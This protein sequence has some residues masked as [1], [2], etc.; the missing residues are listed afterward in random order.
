MNRKVK[1][2]FA[3]AIALA[4]PRWASAQLITTSP[5]PVTQTAP[6]TVPASGAPK[7]S[8]GAPVISV[9][10]ASQEAPVQVIPAPAAAATAAPPQPKLGG[11]APG[12]DPEETRTPYILETE[13]QPAGQDPLGPTPLLKVGILQGL[14][15][16]DDAD[17]AKWKVAGWLDADF[18]Y[19]STG[20]GINNIAPVMNR[21]GDEALLRQLGVLIS[22]PLDQSTWSWGFNAIFIAGADASFLGPTAG[23]WRNTDPRFGTQFTDLN[24]TAHLPILTEGGVNVKIGRQ[25]TVLGPMGA[26]AW[27]RPLN[28]SDYAWYNLEEGRYTGISADWHIS[29]Q[30]TWYNGIEYGGWGVFFDGAT[31]QVDFISQINYWLDCDANKTKVWTTVLTGPTGRFQRNGNTTTFEAGILHNWNKYVYTILDYQMT[32]SK[33]PIFFNP[34]PGYQERAYDV[35]MYT[36]VHLNCKWD[37]T[38]RLEWYRDVDG[39][40]YPGGFGFPRT[41]YFAP[42]IGLNYHP[43]KWAEF[44]PEVRYDYATNPRFGE[45]LNFK[46][47]VTISADVLLKF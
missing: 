14:I 39:G 23:G 10:P 24:F 32:Y 45:N 40:G 6:A 3:L 26:L 18:T 4:G 44:R 31:R 34:G 20:H 1:I 13:G 30:L 41:S 19:R 42:T 36:G 33:A 21:F 17:K 5:A 46:N 11:P 22:R 43:T 9:T 29:K 28:S 35:Y 27:Q 25:T 2:A 12:G 37:A 8:F 38:T 47:Q 7:V 16:G 15:F